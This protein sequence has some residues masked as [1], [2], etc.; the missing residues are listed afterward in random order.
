M[1]NGEPVKTRKTRKRMPLTRR[2]CQAINILDVEVEYAIT[3]RWNSI[4][5][6]DVKR[7]IIAIANKIQRDDKRSDSNGK[8]K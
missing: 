7:R 2:L 3:C 1:Q 4:D 5:R 6:D 8:A